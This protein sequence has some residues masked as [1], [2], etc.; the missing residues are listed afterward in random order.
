MLS[1]RDE[2]T[3]QTAIDRPVVRDIVYACKLVTCQNLKVEREND[4]Q[5]VG[6]S[7]NLQVTSGGTNK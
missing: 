4:G 3:S 6:I 7:G 2:Q 5:F 1:R